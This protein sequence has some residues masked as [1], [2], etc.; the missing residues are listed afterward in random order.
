MYEFSGK[1]CRSRWLRFTRIPDL[2]VLAAAKR[3]CR[4]LD[5][6]MEEP[7]WRLA[8][9]LV[10]QNPIDVGALWTRMLQAIEWQGGLA[11]NAAGALDM[12]VWDLIGKMHGLP[13][14]KLFGGEV[15]PRVMVYASGT[16]Y[17][18]T[19]YRPGIEPPHKSADQLAAESREC[20]QLGFHAVNLA[21]AI[22]FPRKTKRR[23]RP[24]ARRS[25]L[26]RGL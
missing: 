11:L 22:T 15:Q 20:V 16:A 1:S 23:W 2:L 19:H 24:S 25:A 26:T 5:M 12:A 6:I 18:L 14:Y 21:G 13:L 10:G 17:D 3:R 8:E 9:I 7:P 4:P